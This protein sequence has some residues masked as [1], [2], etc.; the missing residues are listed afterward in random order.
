MART[1][2]VLG[3]GTMD[4]G[5]VQVAAQAGY[6]IICDPPVEALEKAQLYEY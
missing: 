2:G 6:T 3:T 5:I 1:V 4:A